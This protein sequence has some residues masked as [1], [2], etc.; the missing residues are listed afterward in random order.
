[1]F[2]VDPAGCSSPIR[3]VRGGKGVSRRIRKLTSAPIRYVVYSHHHFDHIAGGAPF[4]EAGATFIAHRNARPQL[5]RLKNPDVVFPDQ[6]V[7]DSKLLTIGRT[8]VELL[9]LGR[10]HSDNSS[11]S[12]FLPRK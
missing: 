1:M 11:S 9:Y 8:R 10:N 5:Q 7:D 12:P 3:S 6:V 4:K 2:V